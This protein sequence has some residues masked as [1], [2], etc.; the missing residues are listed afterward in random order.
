MFV[1]PLTNT[2]FSVRFWGLCDSEAVREGPRADPPAPH[3]EQQKAGVQ[4]KKRP[5][6]CAFSPSNF[7]ACL[8]SSFLCEVGEEGKKR[9]KRGLGR[10]CKVYDKNPKAGFLS[11]LP[12]LRRPP[13]GG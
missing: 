7:V 9:G 10:I 2:P 12:R 5:P 4:L 8:F 13:T 3:I 11:T 1:K 6:D